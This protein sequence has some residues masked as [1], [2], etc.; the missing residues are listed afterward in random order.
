[1][2]T[3]SFVIGIFFFI[4]GF[5]PPSAFDAFV[6]FTL[7]SGIG[8]SLLN[9]AFLVL[10]Q[11]QTNSVEIGKTISLTNVFLMLPS[12]PSLFIIALMDGTIPINHVFIISGLTI[13]AISVL[14]YMKRQM[15]I[16][17]DMERG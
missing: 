5:L 17:H 4:S 2:I 16:N 6:F 8:Y 13:S 11:I 3:S 14:F 15:T 1:M 9:S 10:L 12:L 7:L